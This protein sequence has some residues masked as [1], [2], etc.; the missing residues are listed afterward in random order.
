MGGARASDYDCRYNLNDQ[1]NAYLTDFPDEISAN[2]LIVFEIGSNDV[3]DALASLA[4]DP[5]GS[6]Q[7]ITTA[8]YN[9]GLA[10]EALYEKGARRFL[11]MNVPAI[12]ETPAVKTLDSS[13]PYTA[14][15]ANIFAQNFNSGLVSLQSA[16]NGSPGIDVRIL[17]IYELLY[18]IIDEPASYGIVNTEDACVTPNEPP[19]TCKKPDTYLFWDGIHP[20][21]AVH[22]IVAQKAAEVLN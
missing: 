16:L 17:D 20:T 1:L 12:G 21:K 2:T 19:F 3:R 9:I 22:E 5:A 8:L 18:E 10:V 13:I 4:D 14:Y 11:L 7:I 15:Y 6:E